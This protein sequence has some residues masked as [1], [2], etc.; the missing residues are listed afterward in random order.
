M[1]SYHAWFSKSRV[2]Y[3]ILRFSNLWSF[4]K[5]LTSFW[6]Y[7]IMVVIWIFINPRTSYPIVKKSAVLY[8]RMNAWLPQVQIE[9]IQSNTGSRAPCTLPWTLYSCTPMWIMDSGP[10]IPHADSGPSKYSLHSTSSI[11]RHMTFCLF[12]I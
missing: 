5:Y 2:C 9:W 11:S 12:Y 4:S 3:L 7:V 10:S 1:Q 8:A 6:M